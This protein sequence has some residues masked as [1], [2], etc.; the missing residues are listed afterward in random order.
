M[1][2]NANLIHHVK[3]QNPATWSLL[4]LAATQELV[5]IHSASKSFSLSPDLERQQPRLHGLLIRIM[6]D[7]QSSIHS[8]PRAR[9]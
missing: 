4:K 7:W 6:E 1:V 5:V 2:R 8:R 3:T 9:H